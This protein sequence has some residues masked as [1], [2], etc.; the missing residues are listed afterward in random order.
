M[1]AWLIQKS[2]DYDKQEVSM[3]IKKPE[4]L[5]TKN[6]FL[7]NVYNTILRI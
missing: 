3:P 1:R 2:K 6:S 5:S 7:L 4:S